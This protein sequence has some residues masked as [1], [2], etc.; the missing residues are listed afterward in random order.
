MLEDLRGLLFSSLK[1]TSE[2]RLIKRTRRLL[3]KMVLLDLFRP[4]AARGLLD[5]LRLCLSRTRRLK[6]RFLLRVC[7]SSGL[8]L[9]LFRRTFR[10]LDI[11]HS[12]LS[13]S[14]ELSPQLV[15][16]FLV[17]EGPAYGLWLIVLTLRS[18]FE[19]LL[20]DLWRSLLLE[21]LT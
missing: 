4:L 17:R 9:T 8:R 20:R 1:E 2:L 10:S 16:L 7:L 19:I 5:G 6:L 3:L 12:P 18:L 21:C 13:S 14:S 15:D 11:F